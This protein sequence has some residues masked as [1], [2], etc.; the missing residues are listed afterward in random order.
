MSG[1]G[2][3]TFFDGTAPLPRPVEILLGRDSLAIV[4]LDGGAI[5]TWRLD[6]IDVADRR[7]A[8]LTLARRGG[9]AR[10]KPADP[11]LAAALLQ[12]LGP[13]LKARAWRGAL[14]WI[15]AG[16]ALV[17]ALGLFLVVAWPVTADLLAR[18]IPPQAF[19]R[20]GDSTV[21]ALT[22]G[23]RLCGDPYARGLLEGMARKLVRGSDRPPPRITVIRSKQS[24]A[25]A[26][27][28]NR[29]IVLSGLITEATHPNEVAGVLAHE[30]GHLA[31]DHPARQFVRQAGLFL[32]VE[33]F[34]GGSSLGGF[35]ATAVATGYSRAFEREADDFALAAL[36]R[37]GYDARPVAAFFER[38]SAQE[39]KSAVPL[40][41][42][43]GNYLS[44][45]PASDERAAA[46]AQGE[47]GARA[48]TDEAFQ[49]LK[50]ACGV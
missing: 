35:G 34:T 49:A 5:A 21:A 11:D 39:K 28:G 6:E 14:A 18:L 24:N 15:G 32:L 22:R 10:L 25:F 37:A 46:F 42:A 20:L 29:V 48:L 26:L 33:M 4:G 38:I 31:H 3:G 36:H 30:I 27:P 8:S 9:E 23:E 19:D 41:G 40:L 16:A 2:R 45:H 17:A 13:G 7:P 44:T 1:R 43:L 50:K 12:A 47:P